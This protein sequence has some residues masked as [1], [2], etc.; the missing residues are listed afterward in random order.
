MSC[1]KELELDPATL[2]ASALTVVHTRID[3]PANYIIGESE[4]PI[5]DHDP[6]QGLPPELQNAR[7]AR[8]PTKIDLTKCA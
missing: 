2:D 3:R 1:V 8:A 7:K 5:S 6:Q 4:D